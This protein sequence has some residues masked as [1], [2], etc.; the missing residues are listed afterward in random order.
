MQ[1]SVEQWPDSYRKHIDK[2]IAQIWAK[3]QSPTFD[4]SLLTNYAEKLTEA[5]IKGFGAAVSD[6]DWNTPN[7][8][9][10]NALKTNVW[11]FSAAKTH[12]QLRD[13]GKALVKADGTVKDFKDFKIQA[14]QISGMQLNW[15]R[16]EYDTAIGGATMAG[17]WVQ[18]QAQKHLFPYLAFD[19]VM[20]KHTSDLCGNLDGVIKPVDDAFW[21]KYYPPNHFNCRST[22]RQVADGN[23]T[24]DSK[25]SYPEKM[26]SMFKVNLAE[27]GLVFPIDHAY[28]TDVPAHIINNATLYMPIKEQ[29][30]IRYKSADGTVLK[31]HRKTELEAKGDLADLIKVSQLDADR[32]VTVD[33]LPEI[34]ASETA[35]REK[36]LPGAKAG[37]NPDRKVTANG[38]QQYDEIE[39]P[40]LPISHKKLQNRIA[41]A[42]KQADSVTILL[43]EEYSEKVLGQIVSERFRHVKGLN[44]ITFVNKDGE[45]TEYLKMTKGD[46][47]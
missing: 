6:A 32:G 43:D 3:K 25:I 29:Y 39:K 8:D 11:Q 2:L 33:I 45:F 10:I 16:T 21:K 26:P 19:A 31:I 20:D 30:L 40:T 13:M 41:H 24:D 46:K 28:Y 36:I 27:N 34:H 23:I 18:I 35:L 38:K 37:K 15:L 12:T 42:A 17:K 47:N 9:M 7:Y 5:V 1:L 44:K 22:V 14:Q 4:V